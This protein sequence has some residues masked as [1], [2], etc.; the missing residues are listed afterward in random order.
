MKVFISYRRDDSRGIT[1]RIYDRLVDHYGEDAI[2]KD[3]DSIPKGSDF[4][5]IIKKAVSM[6]DVLLAVIGDRW[7]GVIDKTT[8]RRIDD[9]N[10]FVRIE[11]EIALQ[12]GIMVIPVLINGAQMPKATKLPHSLQ[13]LAFRNGAV[14]RHDPDFHRDVNHLIKLLTEHYIINDLITQTETTPGST[15]LVPLKEDS[16]FK[17]VTEAIKR[18]RSNI[19]ALLVR[20]QSAYVWA[21]QGGEGYRCAIDDFRQASAI[22]GKL[23][24]PH[25]GLGTVYYDL[26]MFDI[27]KRERYKIREKGKM[28]LNAKTHLPEMMYPAVEL[29]FD[30]QIISIMQAALDEFNTGLQMQQ[31][32]SESGKASVTVFEP[33]EIAKRIHSLRVLLGYEPSRG[34]DQAMISVFTMFFTRFDKESLIGLF[35]IVES[36][37]WWQFWK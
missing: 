7:L 5:Q 2:F 24:D 36:K 28:R 19:N 23:A 21:R 32:H 20:G 8:R 3:V 17:S 15:L 6:C 1:E 18:D 33:Q 10:D 27:V 12:R 26:A 34:P 31:F 11:I 13:E 4:R 14:V 35:E 37:K 16:L 9:K 29:F 22:D 30:K 25:F